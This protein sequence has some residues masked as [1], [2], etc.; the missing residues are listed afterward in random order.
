MILIGID[1]EIGPQVYKTDPA[2]YFVGYKATACGQKEQE[3]LNFLEKKYKKVEE[4]KN[5]DEETTI[6][7]E[8]WRHLDKYRCAISY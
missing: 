5:M 1:D 3:A 8:Y 6:E 7:V 2:G 4:V